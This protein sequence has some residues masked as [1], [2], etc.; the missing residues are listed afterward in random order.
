MGD[1]I[2]I[3]DRHVVL[4]K[5]P[6]SDLW[7]PLRSG[8]VSEETV[9]FVINRPLRPGYAGRAETLRNFD[10]YDYVLNGVE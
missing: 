3:A 8:G 5:A 2:V 9:P 10:I 1:L 7:K 4:G 6:A